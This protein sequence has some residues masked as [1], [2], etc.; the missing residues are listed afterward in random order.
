MLTVW[1]GRLVGL[2][3]RWNNESEYSINHREEMMNGMEGRV[4]KMNRGMYSLEKT[5]GK[6]SS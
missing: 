2:F 4:N 5:A 6:L 3:D 1:T